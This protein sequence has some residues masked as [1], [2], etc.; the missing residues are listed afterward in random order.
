MTIAS[1]GGSRNRYAGSLPHQLAVVYLPI[2]ELKPHERNAR[3][4]PCQR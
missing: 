2:A 4:P 3:T 1:R